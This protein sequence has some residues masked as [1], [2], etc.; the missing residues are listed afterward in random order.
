MVNALRRSAFTLI[1]LIFAIVIIAIAVI[2]LPRM[3]QVI[4]TG[5]EGNIVQE[6][7]FAA[8]T[9]LNQAVAANWDE[10]SLVDGNTSFARVIDNGNCENNSSLQTYRQKPG[11]IN[12]PKHR[13]CVDS[14]NTT[15]S[16]ATLTAVDA[17]DDYEK[18]DADLS[19]PSVSQSGYKFA[20]KTTIVVTHPATFNGVLNND[21]KE[22]NA[23]ISNNATPITTLTTY[24]ANIGE[25]DYHK[26]TY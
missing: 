14:N 20:Y 2:S 19:S 24:S 3:T 7:I 18:T 25:V 1:E 15:V 22:I 13:R 10:N 12:Q 16:N 21:M 26:R 4:A 8:S 6:A 23:T 17:L 9:E 11:H 5:I